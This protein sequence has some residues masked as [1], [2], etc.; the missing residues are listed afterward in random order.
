MRGVTLVELLVVLALLGV[1]TGLAGVTLG[2]L[3]APPV[4]E[5]LGELQAARAAAVRTGRPTEWSHE[6]TAIR[7]RPD[8][9]SSGGIVLVDGVTIRIDPVTGVARLEE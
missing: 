1:L 9:S 8:G 5:P 4:S 6:T 2:S 3:R 7:F